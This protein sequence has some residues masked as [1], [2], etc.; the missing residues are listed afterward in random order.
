M[1]MMTK[2]QILQSFD[3]GCLDEVA[4]EV[5]RYGANLT[6][7][8]WVCIDGTPKRKSKA[9]HHGLTWTIERHTGEV[10]RLGWEIP[11]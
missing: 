11:D 5:Q 4:K 8:D 7:H 9:Q 6:H 10:I 2:R 1:P 3:K